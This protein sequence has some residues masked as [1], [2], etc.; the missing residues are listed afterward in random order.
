M[1]ALTLDMAGARIA[2][3]HETG[4]V[5]GGRLEW[6]GTEFLTWAEHPNA[7]D[8]ETYALHVQ[9]GRGWMRIAGVWSQSGNSFTYSGTP[10][11]L[12]ASGALNAEYLTLSDQAFVTAVQRD[13][14]LAN[15]SAMVSLV[16]EAQAAAV[17]AGVEAA[18]AAASVLGVSAIGEIK[19]WPV[20]TPPTGC[21]LCDGSTVSRTAYPALFAVI[22]TTFG[23]GDGST[24]FNLPDFRERFPAGVGGGFDLAETGNGAITT[25]SNGAHTHTVTVDGHVLT[26][27]EIPAHSHS[28]FNAANLNYGGSG[29]MAGNAQSGQTGSIGGG[30]AHNHTASTASNGA[31]THTATAIPPYLAVYFIIRVGA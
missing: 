7:I 25:S 31:H 5:L 27:N 15:S 14:D 6:A 18:A 19:M 21:K 26:I 10:L 3:T 17:S 11:T 29:A 13:E 24:T 20:A 16:A 28:T 8:G 22:G 2:T 1:A 12:H 30:Q 4:F 23:A 9:D